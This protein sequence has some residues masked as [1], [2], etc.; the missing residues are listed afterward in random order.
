MT[1]RRDRRE[2]HWNG[3]AVSDGTAAGRVLRIHSGGRHSIY[4]TTLDTAEVEREVR[5]YRAAMR[6]AR[7]QLLAL[8]KR[9]ARTLGDE[10]SYIFDAHLLM[11]ED[12]KLKEDV[13]AVIRSEQ[14]GSEWAVKVVTDRLLAVYD[15]IKDDYLRE[16]SSDIEDVT[17]RLLVA[18]SGESMGGRRLTEDAVVV[19]EELM[20]STLAELDFTHIKAI[21][22]DV[23]GWTSHTAIIARGL[24]IPAIVGLRDFYRAARTGDTVVIDAGRGEVVLHPEKATLEQCGAE[25]RAAREV[26]ARTATTEDLHAPL[27]TRDRV[28][29]TLRAN[30]ELPVEYEW[31]SLYGARGIGLFRSEFLLSHRGTMPDED[32]QYD[33]YVE[34]AGIAGEDGV[35]VRLFDLGGDKLPLSRLDAVEERNPALGLRAIRFCLQRPDVLRTQAR[36]VLRAAAKGCIDLVLPMVSDV[37]DVRRAR[38]I[39]EEERSRLEAEGKETGSIRL[40][41]MIE[42]PSAVLVADKL[43]R[44]V[45]FFS[46]GTN[47]LVQYT[48]AVDRG[49]DEVADWFRSL[50]P[51]VLQ[52]IRRTLDAARGA[53][54]PSVVCGEMAA[55]PAYAAVLLGLGARELSMSPTAIP[56]VR[57]TIAGLELKEAE[58]IAAECLECAAADEVEDIVRL[59]LGERWPKLFPPEI[60]PPA[61]SR[62]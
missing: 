39:I 56:R 2:Q 8:K 23:G 59:R 27:L 11:L 54:I 35:T 42:V 46:L 41:A 37:T 17:R 25:T 58:A 16:R 7:R 6:L 24:G 55:S 51:A 29:V 31:V 20:P 47:D 21:A 61:K 36:A 15:E 38:A 3:I 44:E 28:G 4:R 43:A 60:L 12:R 19:A 62:G 50:H 34:L 45:D 14:V 32:E 33:A 26:P 5:R 13:E 18:L 10:H 1:K 40:G 53:G 30:V 52:S 57:R 48:L 49:N 9:A 22:T